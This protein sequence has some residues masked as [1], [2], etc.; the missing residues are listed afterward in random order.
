MAFGSHLPRSPQTAPKPS[1]SIAVP[2]SKLAHLTSDW[3]KH[4]AP[5]GLTPSQARFASLLFGGSNLLLSG[6]AGT[7]KTYLIKA[8]LAFLR[9]K[10]VNVGV[11]ATTGIAALQAGGQTIH[12]FAGIGLGDDTVENL[13]KKV[14][15]NAKAKDRIKAIDVLFLDEVSMAKGEL[16]DK[17][18]G[19][20]RAIRRN[21]QAFGGVQLVAVGD[22]LQLEPVFKGD[23]LQE[24]AFQCAAWRAANV[25]PVVLKEQMRQRSADGLLSVLTDLRVGDTS[26]LSQLNARVGAI[27][28]NDGIEAVRLFCRNVDVD[29]YNA[30]RLAQLTTQAKAY[31][32][33]DVGDPRYTD[34]FNR[35]CPAP[36]VLNLKVGALVMLLVNVDVEGRGLVNGSVGKVKS[37][38]PDGV[39]VQFKDGPALIGLNEW[40]IKEQ[41]VGIDGKIK[42]K[43]VATRRQIP[44]RLA[45]SCSIHKAQGQT[46]DRVVV[47]LNEAFGNS[48]IYTALS[49]V[50]DMESLSL[51][52]PIDPSKVR[53]NRHCVRFYEDIEE[54]EA[55]IL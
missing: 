8:L 23:E 29:R 21:S 47:D 1:P 28:P 18:D 43:T 14:F 17:V 52:A 30:E 33:M 16:L 5:L 37:F 36:E 45:Y 15:K 38:G 34:A 27:F 9:A 35:N 53:V 54:Q 13:I 12:S 31:R 40:G 22:W 3:L 48:M 32:A 24:L 11:T 4:A 19:V 20:F 46:L 10:N 26:S 44:L 55:P 7:G 25:R 49:R 39:H 6:P 2:S 41:E 50:R 51:A 42:L